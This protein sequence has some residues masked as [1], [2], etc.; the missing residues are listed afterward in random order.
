MEKSTSQKIKQLEGLITGMAQP[1]SD[2]GNVDMGKFQIILAKIQ[3]DL[4]SKAN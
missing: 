2:G 4:E 3:S 1:A